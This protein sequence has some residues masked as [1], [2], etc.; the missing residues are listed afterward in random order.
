MLNVRQLQEKAQELTAR[1]GKDWDELP[2]EEQVEVMGWVKQQVTVSTSDPRKL[3]L[4]MH[5]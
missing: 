4:H 2:P 1:L 5:W 3:K